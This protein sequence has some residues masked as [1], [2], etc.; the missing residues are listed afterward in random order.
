MHQPTHK[1]LMF[2]LSMFYL[3]LKIFARQSRGS[4]P[5][6]TQ[7]VDPLE[8]LLDKSHRL[9]WPANVSK[10]KTNQQNRGF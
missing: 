6:G 4:D 1:V 5:V 3:Q 2:C 8:S 9:H 7:L 10:S